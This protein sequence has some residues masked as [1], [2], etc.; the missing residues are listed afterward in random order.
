MKESDFR[1]QWASEKP[2]YEAWGNLVVSEISQNLESQGINLLEF[3][4][5]PAKCRLKD[6]SSLVDKAFYRPSKEYS[7]PYNDIEDKVGARF[8]VLLL[9][10]IQIISD[11]VENSELWSFDA[12]KHFE[13]DRERDPL[14]FTYQS[15]H[16][17]L[18]PKVKIPIG[19]LTIPASTP[20][21]IQIRTLLQ[22]AHSELTHDA[23][24]KAKRVV[25]PKVHRTV[26][27]SMA[28]IETT[29]D[30]FS[31]VTNLLNRGPLEDLDILNRLD[32][33]Y[34]SLTEIKPYTQKSSIAIWDTYEQFITE[35]LIDNIQEFLLRYD[36]LGE[37]I[38]KKYKESAFYQQS[39]V[40]F[41]YWMLKNKRQRFLRDWPYP[42][43]ILEPLAIDLGVNINCD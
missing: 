13:V 23:I 1:E 27:K 26:A 8:V 6:V 32:G 30:F 33:L 41:V 22:H 21:E 10:G 39:T 14:L 36:F 9:E 4:K 42:K 19:E 34:F 2:L 3:F 15:V 25:Q 17:V 12:C 40:L 38:K 28:L 16:Y 31:S 11:C 5:I 20:C 18:Y 37:T 35:G 7:D 29:D 43:E 24:Y